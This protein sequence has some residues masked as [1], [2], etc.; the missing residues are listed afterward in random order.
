[1]A[2]MDEKHGCIEYKWPNLLG[3]SRGVPCVSIARNESTARDCLI[4]AW[5][6]FSH[7]PSWYVLCLGQW[8]QNHEPCAEFTSN[9]RMLIEAMH[10][11]SIRVCLMSAP[12]DLGNLSPYRAAMADCAMIYRTGFLDVYAYLSSDSVDSSWWEVDGS[13]P[14]HFSALGARKLIGYFDLPGNSCLCQP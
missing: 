5:K 7:L 4:R 13:V 12:V 10:R 8:S 11:R 14:C 9:L 6:V 3:R 1:V 2:V